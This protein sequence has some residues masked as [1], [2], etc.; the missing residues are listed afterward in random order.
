MAAREAITADPQRS[1]QDWAELAGHVIEAKDARMWGN[2][3]AQ[4]VRLPPGEAWQA[5]TALARDGDQ[6]AATAALLLASDC[7][8]LGTRAA[9][10]ATHHTSYVDRLVLGMP[11]QWSQFIRALDSDVQQRLSDRVAD[12]EGI[13]GTIDFAMMAID[14]FFSADDPQIQID[15][16]L[17]N[18]DDTEA[19]ADLRHLT[20]ELHDTRAQRALGARLLRS[21]DIGERAE[22]RAIL[23]ELARAGD[24]EAIV[25]LALDQADPT[26]PPSDRP[27]W[28]DDW[29]TRA[30]GLGKW[31][32]LDK[33]IGNL[34][35]ENNPVEA[36]AWALYRFQLAQAGCFESGQPQLYF[37]AQYAKDVFSWQGALNE[38]QI[39]AAR[40]GLA[41]INLQWRAKADA[42]L[43]CGG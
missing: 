30:A 34:R 2:E 43:G 32:L 26:R 33:Q 35:A 4:L 22:G 21:H 38:A 8:S 25:F 27:V 13:G 18:P 37:L 36:L 3:V 12:C 39:E 1:A 28:T 11:A 17:D 41:A 42:Y 6:R 16:S 40:N 19:I 29:I 15:A 5:L 31:Q 10:D 14:R 23:E 20:D 7:Q 9:A 24:A